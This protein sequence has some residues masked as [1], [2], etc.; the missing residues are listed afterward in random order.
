MGTAATVTERTPETRSTPG[1]NDFLAR[2]R[3]ATVPTETPAQ[4]TSE[5]EAA[6]ATDQAQAPES[7]KTDKKVKT[8]E[9]LQ[10]E[11]SN[12]AKANLRLGAERADLSRKLEQQS[13]ELADLKARL[14]GT[15]VEPTQEQKDR[16]AVLKA[17]FEKFEQRRETSKHE[18][19]KEF[20]EAYVLEQIYQDDAPFTKLSR[21]KPWLV[22]RV[23]SAERPV[24]EAIAAVNEEAVLT[25]FGRT[26]AEV[27][28]KAT[29]ILRPIL[30]EEFK[31]EL[32]QDGGV[33]PTPIVPSLS[34]VR[35]AGADPKLSGTESVRTFSALGLNPHNRV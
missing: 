23:M 1:L 26:E 5:S 10:V 15:Y 30:F 11:L 6:Q 35:T 14:D 3:T 13:K 16:E 27:L 31:K 29:E 34:R 2:Q 28:K 12:Q 7:P 9:E 33:K 17:E 8:A 20:G 18:A 25:K 32:P 21:E 24:H 4:T 22:Q 19:V